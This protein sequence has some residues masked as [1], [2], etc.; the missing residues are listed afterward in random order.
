M[1]PKVKEGPYRANFHKHVIVAAHD[2]FDP[3]KPPFAARMPS[4]SQVLD[5]PHSAPLPEGAGA[6]FITGAMLAGHA[7]AQTLPKILEY[8]SR[9]ESVE[10]RCWFLYV[11]SSGPHI[12]RA[13]EN[14]AFCEMA[15]SDGYQF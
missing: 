8:V 4:L 14:E 12:H 3:A 15:R 2:M 5:D 1:D 7:D 11:L 10:H 6:Y 9:W 13:L